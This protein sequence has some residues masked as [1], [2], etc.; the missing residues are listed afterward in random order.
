MKIILSLIFSLFFM[1]LASIP[2]KAKE[3]VPLTLYGHSTVGE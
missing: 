3:D 1:L 2:L